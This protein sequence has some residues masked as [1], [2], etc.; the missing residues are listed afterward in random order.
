MSR[1]A[2]RWVAGSSAA[3][4]LLLAGWWVATVLV[5][6]NL[7]TVVPRRV[8]RSAQPSASSLQRIV[9]ERGI[10]TVVNLRGSCSPLP[11]YV[12]EARTVSELGISQED[13]SFSAIH[14]P[15]ASELRELIDVLD[16]A[17]YPILLHCRHGADR[18]GMASAIVLLLQDGV[19]FAQARRELGIRYG[20]LSFGKTG[21]LDRF[22]DLYET[23]LR[24]EGKEHAPE[25]FR[26]WVLSEYRGGWCAGGVE[27]VELLGKATAGKPIG[28]RV[29]LHNRSAAAWQFKPTLNAGVHVFYR[30][31]DSSG[32]PV[33]EGRAGFLEATV[34][35]GARFEVTMVVPPQPAGTYRLAVD[36]IEEFH[37]WFVQVGAEPWEEEIVVE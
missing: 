6:Q 23:W 13:L 30:L 19:S 10:R 35:P 15:S 29:G 14:L 28:F 25:V 34:P 5:G 36:L 7:H 4:V 26:H 37:C 12:D 31:F 8:Y 17:E 11:W 20:H 21:Y 18:T 9:K 1:R 27:R 2:A 22:F 33:G 32:L 3:L 16:H 24:D